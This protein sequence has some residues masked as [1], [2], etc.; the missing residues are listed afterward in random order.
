MTG[1]HADGGDVTNAGGGREP[2]GNTTNHS[3]LPQRWKPTADGAGG[4]GAL[5]ASFLPTVDSRTM[6]LLPGCWEHSYVSTLRVANRAES[7]TGGRLRQSISCCRALCT[8]I[9]CCSCAGDCL[10]DIRIF[11]PSDWPL[12]HQGPLASCGVVGGECG[13]CSG[14]PALAVRHAPFWIPAAGARGN[15][16]GADKSG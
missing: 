5:S 12:H 6:A 4:S 13:A 9:A 2:G 7:H 3:R 14:R 15:G 11:D 8:S 10:A 16:R 1:L